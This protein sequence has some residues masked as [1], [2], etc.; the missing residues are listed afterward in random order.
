MVKARFSSV[1]ATNFNHVF[2]SW[3]AQPSKRIK[4]RSSRLK[5]FFKIG[6]L[7]S[8]TIFTGKH[9]CWSLFL[10]KLQAFMLHKSR[11][12]HRCFPVNIAKLL[13]TGF[14]LE[15]LLWLPLKKVFHLSGASAE[16]YSDPIR[17]SKLEL[18]A[19]IVNGLK[20]LFS[21]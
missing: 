15:Y 17:T 5:M 9:L 14:F 7:K 12:H 2:V 10:I 20:L 18:I 3:E 4:S 13:R 16:A 6:V 19:K 21:R 11:L 8:F 1:F